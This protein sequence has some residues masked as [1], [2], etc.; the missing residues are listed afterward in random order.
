MWSTHDCRVTTSSVS[1][2]RLSVTP[3]GNPMPT[4]GTPIPHPERLAHTILPSVSVDA[5]VWTFRIGGLTP[6][7]LPRLSSLARQHALELHSFAACVSASCL[8][9][10]M[11]FRAVCRGHLTGTRTATGQVA[12]VLGL[13]PE[14]LDQPR[15]ARILLGQSGSVGGRAVVWEQGTRHVPVWGL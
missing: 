2:Y 5:S 6:R 11:S 12:S 13:S 9:I 14:A 7:G 3:K 8:F 1:F 10:V 15:K 4:T